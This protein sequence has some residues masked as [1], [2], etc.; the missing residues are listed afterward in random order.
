[1]IET[2]SIA[3]T[4]N[5]WAAFLEAGMLGPRPLIRNADVT[6]SRIQLGRENVPLVRNVSG[7]S[8]CSWVTSLRNAYGPYARAETDIV[9]MNRWL[10]PLYLAGS[11]LAEA[12]LVSGG[13]GGG[14]FLNNWNLATNLYASTLR[15]DDIVATAQRIAKEDPKLP[16]VLRS[17][18]APLHAELIARLADAGFLLLPSRQVWIV[19]DPGSGEWRLRRD[20][21]RD[22]ALSTSSRDRWTW[23][24]G[25]EFTDDDFVQTVRLYGQLYRE[26]YPEYNPD[27]TEDFFR[28]GVKTGFLDLNGFRETGA[29]E[30]CGL[31]GMAHR[32]AVSCTPVLGYDTTAPVERG[33][34]RLLMLRAF[35]E[36]ERRKTM[37]HCSAGA[38]LFKFNRGAESHVEFAA[39][40]AEHLPFYRRGQLAALGRVVKQLVVPYLESHRL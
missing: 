24:R 23:V 28:V 33:L 25:E 37:L 4:E 19:P 3:A 20:A 10:Q 14:N 34:Y 1:M 13:L 36:C 7:R 31:V 22:L 6:I 26:R 39:I 8:T 38:G 9:H 18:T 35:Q 29:R 40:W 17:L 12:V 5:P 11:R 16:V 27:Y 30:L 15:A 21:K 2:S 32:E